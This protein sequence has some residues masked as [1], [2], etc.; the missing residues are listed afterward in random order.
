L[1]QSDVLEGLFRGRL[2]L[3]STTRTFER[4]KA[5]DIKLTRFGELYE[6]GHHSQATRLLKK[7]VRIDLDDDDSVIHSHDP[8]L[9]W[10]CQN[11]FLDYLLLVS[12][13]IGL[14]A[15]LP[16]TRNVPDYTFKMQLDQPYRTFRTKHAALGFDPKGSMLFV[17]F[18]NNEHVWIAMAPRANLRRTGDE[19]PTGTCSGSTRMKT[20]HYYALLAWIALIMRQKGLKNVFL[21][22]DYPDI[23]DSFVFKTQTNIL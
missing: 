15:I 16:N 9:L 2:N 12:D 6:R 13:K 22:E 23:D 19:V 17:G 21:T 7:R 11:F 4:E 1:D 8:S 10:H 20:R 5:Y 3:S 14:H 18:Q